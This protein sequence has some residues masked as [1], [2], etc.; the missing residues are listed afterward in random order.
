[1]VAPAPGLPTVEETEG[2]H[3]FRLD[4]GVSMTP[5]YWTSAV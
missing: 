1:M 5:P 2:P 3:P 4:V